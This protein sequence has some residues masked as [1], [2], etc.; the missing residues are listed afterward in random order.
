MMKLH[1]N[2][3]RVDCI[4]AKSRKEICKKYKVKKK[5]E[6]IE[7]EISNG[8]EL[9]LGQVRVS[10]FVKQK[11]LSGKTQ[12]LVIDGKIV[13]FHKDCVTGYWVNTSTGKNIRL[14][15]EKLRLELGLT[16]G[17]MQNYDVHHIDKNKDNNDISNLQLVNKVEHVKSHAILQVH[18][19]IKK[20][21]EYCGCEYKSSSNIA[22]RQRFCSEKCKMKYRRANGLDNEERICKY[23]GKKFICN[24]TLP[25]KFC[26]KHC[27]GK[28]NYHKKEGDLSL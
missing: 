3:L 12:V 6:K 18:T 22:H 2:Q 20:I 10:D 4:M 7:H 14:H 23:C 15:R 13:Q 17:Q 27:A 21:C 26:S 8:V 24:K 9:G 1:Y 19:K 5:K 28:Y 25:T 11:I 16:K